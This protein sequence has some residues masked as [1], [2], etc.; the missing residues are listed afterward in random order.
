MTEHRTSTV[1][2]GTATMPYVTP[3]ARDHGNPLL[4]KIHATRP[5]L[6]DRER[7]KKLAAIPAI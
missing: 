4:K 6:A 7:P 5:M 2:T 3:I 1:S